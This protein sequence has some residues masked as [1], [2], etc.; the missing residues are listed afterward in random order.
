MMDTATTGTVTEIVIVTGVGTEV[1]VTVETTDAA[2]SL[3]NSMTA[4]SVGMKTTVALGEIIVMRNGEDLDKFV[5]VRRA[6]RAV[7]GARDGMDLVP[8]SAGPLHLR[9]RSLFPSGDAK[10]LD[11]MFMLQDTNSIRPCKPNKQVG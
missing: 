2:T 11:G 10:L 5:V 1:M 7:V 3:V 8:P 4:G 9:V 6:P